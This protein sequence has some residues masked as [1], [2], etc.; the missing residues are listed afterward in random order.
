MLKPPVNELGL[1]APSH[2]E[3]VY[4]DAGRLSTLHQ[5]LASKFCRPFSLCAMSKVAMVRKAFAKSGPEFA[6]FVASSRSIFANRCAIPSASPMCGVV[7]IIGTP[8]AAR[9]AFLGL[10]TLQHR[11]QD[12]AGILTYDTDGFH[13]V[14]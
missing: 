11:G 8:D 9:E 13:R 12:A 1:I 10:T 14:K 7:G 5:S 6:N 4:P 3:K 2:V